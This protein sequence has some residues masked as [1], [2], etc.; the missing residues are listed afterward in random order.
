MTIQTARAAG[1]RAA[2]DNS[3]VFYRDRTA[4]TPFLDDPEALDPSDFDD[5]P[6]SERRE[7]TAA[8]RQAAFDWRLAARIRAWDDR[9]EDREREAKARAAIKSRQGIGDPDCPANDNVDV[10]LLG[11]LAKDG[12]D[13]LCKVVRRYRSL[14]ALCEMQPLQGADYGPTAGMSLDQFQ[15]PLDSDAE[16]DKAAAN[17]WAD[18]A[19]PGGEIRY[20]GGRQSRGGTFSLPPTRAVVADEETR[21]RASSFALKFS[22]DKL[23]AQI[24]AKP[25][26]AQLQASLGPLLQ[27]FEDAVLRGMTLSKI[28]KKEGI[29]VKP[30]IAGR[31]LVFRALAVVNG[32]WSEI[33]RRAARLAKEADRRAEARRKEL[34]EQEARFLRK[35]A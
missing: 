19:I 31:A 3:P 26:L 11:V 29:A 35:A 6:A 4:D 34:T 8:E 2:N 20:N 30:A 5:A 12:R 9:A 17:G 23:I 24:D 13:D 28:G 7:L 16:V 15:K 22:A 27:P 10:P 32:A 18:S 21:A 14:V 25:V 33:D 1:L